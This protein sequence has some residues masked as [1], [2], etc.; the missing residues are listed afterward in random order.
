MLRHPDKKDRK[1]D[2]NLENYHLNNP[3]LLKPLRLRIFRDCQNGVMTAPAR[4]RTLY[5]AR[6]H[7]LLGLNILNRA[8][9]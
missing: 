3:R 2:P 5:T 1:R 4:R 6:E 9:V 7:L 8:L